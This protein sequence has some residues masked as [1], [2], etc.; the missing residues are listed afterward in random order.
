MKGQ[1]GQV[2]Q[3]NEKAGEWC[4]ALL[5]IDELKAWGVQAG[6]MVPFQGTA[7]I[8]LKDEQFDIVG[9]I[10]PLLPQGGESDD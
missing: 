5:F 10:A 1:V 8:R 9:G 6:M 2:I 4:G 7:Y 3:A